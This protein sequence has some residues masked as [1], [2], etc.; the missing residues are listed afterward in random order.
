MVDA[1]LKI[2]IT[3]RSALLIGILEKL[4]HVQKEHH[5]DRMWL[6]PN[7]GQILFALLMDCEC[8]EK[9]QDTDHMDL[10]IHFALEAFTGRTG[11]LHDKLSNEQRSRIAEETKTADIN[12]I[13]MTDLML[14][15]LMLIRAGYGP[16]NSGGGHRHHNT[17]KHE[18]S[19][20]ARLFGRLLPTP[21]TTPA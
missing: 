7:F 19:I 10:A 20:V 3:E 12:I 8:E 15:M 1:W 18:R 21:Q 11:P 13:A 6:S 4:G 5:S 14:A 16:R 17:S 9:T 2:T